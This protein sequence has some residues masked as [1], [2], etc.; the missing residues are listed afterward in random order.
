MKH[1]ILFCFTIIFINNLFS[2][3]RI[4]V[5]D[6]I[7]LDE[8]VVEPIGGLLAEKKQAYPLSNLKF[9]KF[10][11]LT[12]QIKISEY[13]ESVPG[14]FIMNNNN[15]AQDARISI[16]GFG[17]R[18]NFGI[19]GIKIFVDGIPETSPDG[20]SQIDNVNLEIIERMNVYRG[21]NSSFFGSSAGGV[22]SITTLE[23][24]EENFVNIGL[25]SG[26]FSTTKTQA[27]LG[28]KNENEKMIFFI[29]NTNSEGY[30]KHSGF[31]NFNANF[32]YLTN[33]GKKNKLQIV[34]NVLDSPDAMDPG[35]LNANELESDR[36]QAR[37]RN[38]EFD[39]RESVKQYKLGVNLKS[40]FNN[41]GLTNSIYYNRRLF[42]GKLP[43]RNGGIIELDKSFWGYKLNFEFENSLNYNLGFSYNNQ[44]DH[45]KR[46]VNDL[47]LRSEI[48]MNQ[49]EKYDNIGLYLFS[50]KK[51][52]KFIFSA[53][54]RYDNNTITLE[55]ILTNSAKITE[56][57]K[58]INPSFNLNYA[59]KNFD[60]F[61]NISSGYETPTLNEL[62]ATIDQSGFNG[63]LKSVKSKSFEI[64]I[65]NYEKFTK[66][67]YNLRYFNILTENEIIPFE[68]TTGQV[69]YQNAGKTIKKGVEFELS[70][71]LNS[72]FMIDYSLT[73][74]EYAFEDFSN[75]EIDYSNNNIAGI[76]NN[77]HKLS[78]KYFIDNLNVIISWKNVGKI[79]ANNSNTTFIEGYDS[80]NFN[81]SSG[82]ALFGLDIT[83]Y[84]AIE[85]LLSENYID[86]I[87]INAF[88]SRFYEPAPKI[89]F[90]SGLKLNLWKKE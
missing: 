50:S 33:L 9:E 27:T 43:F 4:I 19:R 60:I 26:S 1:L 6:S 32:K 42:D 28:I 16:R 73:K 64:G 62:S 20:Q 66:L 75:G 79:Y 88:G 53:G 11:T 24:F 65:S 13:L 83:P 21:N 76:P 56:S 68:S 63:D 8:V 36:R 57:I 12:P 2:Q 51:I 48:V 10:Q 90:M 34:A 17:A 15:F 70:A 69:I 7:K 23:N 25:S 80:I 30:R 31:K 82:V 86:N 29:S 14:L 74:G 44:S 39:A 54:I 47:G 71:K 45:R 46:F 78:L 59:F 89:S 85:N 35:G 18:A 38:I 40:T 58:S 87:R 55:N 22:I 77:F 72:N 84:F 41:F 81:I 49:F 67:K 3:E 61:S 52:G 37:A 5:G